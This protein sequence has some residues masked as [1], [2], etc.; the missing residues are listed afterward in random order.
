M[1][2]MHDTHTH[3]HFLA[4]LGISH[5]KGTHTLGIGRKGKEGQGILENGIIMEVME[6]WKRNGRHVMMGMEHGL[7]TG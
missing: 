4:A 1:G 5:G 7:A 2:M 3:T 6:H